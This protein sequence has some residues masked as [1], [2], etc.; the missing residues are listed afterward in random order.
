[1]RGRS[2]GFGR[3]VRDMQEVRE[4]GRPI[5]LRVDNPRPGIYS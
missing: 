4:L 2:P 1:M 5:T 3:E